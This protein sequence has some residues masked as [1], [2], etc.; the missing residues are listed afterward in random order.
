MSF[1]DLGKIARMLDVSMSVLEKKTS[2]TPST[3]KSKSIDKSTSE[4]IKKFSGYMDESTEKTTKSVETKTVD[5]RSEGENFDDSK[6]IK[7]EG[8]PVAVGVVDDAEQV[9]LKVANLLSQRAN[10][11]DQLTSRQDAVLQKQLAA[12]EEMIDLDQASDGLIGKLIEKLSLDKLKGEANFQNRLMNEKIQFNSDGI[13]SSTLR[14]AGESPEKNSLLTTLNNADRLNSATSLSSIKLNT[15]LTS[16][17]WGAEFGKRIQMLV[18]G[19][20]QQ[21]EIRMDPPELGRVQVRIN[22]SQ[23]QVNLSFTALNANVR[24]ALE[25]NMTRLKDMLNDAG[26]QL[27]EADVG[28]SFEQEAN[29]QADKLMPFFQ[30]RGGLDSEDVSD[31]PVPVT[32][33]AADGLIDYFA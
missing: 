7:V 4:N 15:P 16:P 10:V 14:M 32:F 22:L 1:N 27:G 13:D 17:D 2:N 21:A 19:N 26:L 20:M 5:Q 3:D 33:K 6:E 28:G 31:I 12:V 8:A 30:T 11:L 23:D 24:E 9:R 25:A 29:T 18:K